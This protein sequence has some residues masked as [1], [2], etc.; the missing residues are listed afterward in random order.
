MKSEKTDMLS[1]ELLEEEAEVSLAQ[2]CQACGLSEEEIVK[3]VDA[4]ELQWGEIAPLFPGRSAKQRWYTEL[5]AQN[6]DVKFTF[7]PRKWTPEEDARLVKLV[8]DR[9]LNWKE[10]S[11]LFPGRYVKWHWN[12][13]LSE[14]NP[15]VNYALNSA[16]NI[17]FTDEE[18]AQVLRDNPWLEDPGDGDGDA[19]ATATAT[20]GGAAEG[21]WYYDYGIVQ[22]KFYTEDYKQLMKVDKAM[23]TLA[24]AFNE[25]RNSDIGQTNSEG[26]FI[27]ALSR[28][29]PENFPDEK[30]HYE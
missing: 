10:M 26:E 28:D 8:A 25:N 20:E 1:G 21:G 30:P 24:D 9:K 5:A 29:Y 19:D 27:V 11:P 3:L 22:L 2:L 16:G 23:H 15:D 12:A 7:R 14:Q 4:G 18:K 13:V 17:A 6:P